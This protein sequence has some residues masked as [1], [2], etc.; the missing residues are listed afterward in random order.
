MVACRRR[1]EV[2]LVLFR[3]VEEGREVDVVWGLMEGSAASLSG[4][5]C[6]GEDAI[7]GN[8]VATKGVRDG[9]FVLFVAYCFA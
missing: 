7:V 4:L 1:F 3:F 6:W 5:G 2:F 8:V 9:V